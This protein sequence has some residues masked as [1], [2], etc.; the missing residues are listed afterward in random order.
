MAHHSV[1]ECMKNKLEFFT[2]LY[3]YMNH[4]NDK[5]KIVC[6]QMLYKVAIQF[7][8]GAFTLLSKAAENLAHMN[9]KVAFDELIACLNS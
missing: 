1:R 5:L 3:E 4:P 8:K 9:Q 6:C 7:P 2:Q